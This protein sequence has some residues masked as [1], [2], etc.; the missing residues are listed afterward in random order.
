MAAALTS[1]PDDRSRLPEGMTRIGY[2]ADSTRYAFHDTGAPG[3]L[4]V[5][6]PGEEYGLM[7]PEAE[8]T[9]DAPSRGLGRRRTLQAYDRPAHFASEEPA[10][11]EAARARVFAGPAVNGTGMTFSD[12]LPPHLLASAPPMDAK[13]S[14]PASKRMSAIV[15]RAVSPTKATFAD[16]K[17]HT[18][19]ASFRGA[20][21]LVGR[22]ASAIRGHA[23]EGSSD[24][25]LREKGAY[26]QLE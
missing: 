6:Q 4:F 20:A 7:V 3:T 8:A 15:H 23:K 22:A 16:E 21:R 25:E 17:A 26:A 19:K 11:A 9:Q 5:G 18:R 13:K 2:D 12:I 24:S 1:F 14:S 10:D